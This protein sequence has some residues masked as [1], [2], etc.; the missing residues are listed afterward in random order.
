[1]AT[2]TQPSAN[3]NYRRVAGSEGDNN[4]AVSSEPPELSHHHSQASTRT[5]QERCMDKVVAVA[6]VLAAS[7][8]AYWTDTLHVLFSEET[9]A[10]RR[11]LQLVAIGV[12]IQTVL[13]IYLTV[14][15]PY[16]KGLTDS[17]AWTVY[18]PRVIPVLTA[19][20]VITFLILVRALWP[21]WGFLAPLILSV[22]GLGLLFMLQ[23]VPSW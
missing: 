17:S 19:V 5:F 12:G 6:W 15:L 16:G 13:T 22:E 1:M 21:V 2:S 20:S 10:V 3:P 23:L 4:S 8:V 18:C 11:L 9:A 7:F 14:Y